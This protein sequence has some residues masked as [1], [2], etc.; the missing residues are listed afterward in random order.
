MIAPTESRAQPEDNY[1]CVHMLVDGRPESAQFKPLFHLRDFTKRLGRLSADNGRVVLIKSP[2]S[3]KLGDYF[4]YAIGLDR[5]DFVRQN[6]D[7]FKLV[8]KPGDVAPILRYIVE[9]SGTDCATGVR[10][11]VILL[12]GKTDPDP[13]PLVQELA[14]AAKAQYS[15]H[16]VPM[17][18]GINVKRLRQYVAAEPKR[19][20]VYPAKN[21]AEVKPALDK[22]LKNIE[23]WRIGKALKVQEKLEPKAQPK[24]TLQVKEFYAEPD[25]FSKGESVELRWRVVGADR[26]RI[27][28][29]VGSISDLKNGSEDVKPKRSTTYRLICK[30]GKKT[31]SEEVRI[32]LEKNAP[33][34]PKDEIDAIATSPSVLTW[35][36]FSLLTL[37]VIGLGVI[38]VVAWRRSA[39]VQAPAQDFSA[40][41][42]FDG[43]PG[44]ARARFNC[45]GSPHLSFEVSS[46]KSAVRI[47]RKEPNDIVIDERGISGRHAELRWPDGHLHVID[48]GSTNGTY[49]NDRKVAEQALHPGDIVRFDVNSF[50]ISGQTRVAR[51]SAPPSSDRTM[52]YDVGD[53]SGLDPNLDHGADEVEHPAPVGTLDLGH[54][55]C[56]RHKNRI[57]S[58]VCDMCGRPYCS[59]CL[60][61]VLGEQVCPRCRAA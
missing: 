30:S 23:L 1:V 58:Q 56:M 60:V 26:C 15:I 52:V 10:A 3:D 6:I 9:R 4:F 38:L 61:T 51:G 37:A 44:V 25:T 14:A 41:A 5:K 43:P 17:G 53:L 22:I 35:I 47:G 48:L 33:D 39:P 19:N 31:I 29:G 36:L 12:T 59:E 32:E 28:P 21:E 7:K 46:D 8:H 45:A 34:E 24:T 27:K 42:N 11:V 13:V 54:M 2:H 40:D 49:V 57:A 20:R 50:T 18:T 55:Y 16:V